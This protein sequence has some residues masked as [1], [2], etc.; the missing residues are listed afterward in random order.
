M[1]IRY[2]LF[3]NFVLVC[4]STDMA[5]SVPFFNMNEEFDIIV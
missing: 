4:N 1:K 5:I 2:F 3:T